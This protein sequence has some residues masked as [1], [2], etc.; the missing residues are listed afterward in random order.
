MFD[1]FQ[2][3]IRTTSSTEELL[4]P[5]PCSIIC[6]GGLIGLHKGKGLVCGGTLALELPDHRGP[7]GAIVALFSQACEAGV[8]D[9]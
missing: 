3:V 1:H 5:S 6:S 7:V 8:I 9:M 4:D 2:V